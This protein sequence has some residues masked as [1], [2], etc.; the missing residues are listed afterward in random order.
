MARRGF[1]V[2]V[3]AD[4]AETGGVTAGD[5]ARMREPNHIASATV[6]STAIAKFLIIL[7][8]EPTVCYLQLYRETAA[9][10]AASSS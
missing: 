8:S 1:G 4:V 3:F 10:A 7:T 6:I 5:G 9:T 2:S